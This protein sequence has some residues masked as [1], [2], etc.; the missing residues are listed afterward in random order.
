VDDKLGPRRLLKLVLEQRGHAVL[1]AATG[2]KAL[3]VFRR[4]RGAIRLVLLDV[5]MPGRDGP[6]TLD[7]LRALDPQVRC[8][9]MSGDLGDYTEEELRRRG[10]LAFFHKPFELSRLVQWVQQ[11]TGTTES[12]TTTTPSDARPQ[13]GTTASPKIEGPPAAPE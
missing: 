10:A 11:V 6:A 1:L 13:E 2:D 4:H 5:H 7:A 3:E 8:G 12:K 9:F